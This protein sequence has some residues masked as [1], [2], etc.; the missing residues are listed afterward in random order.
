METIIDRIVAAAG[1]YEGPGDGVES[2][3]FT[4]TIDITPLLDGM[5][6]IIVY[7]AS[8]PDGVVLHPSTPCSHSTCGPARRRCTCCAPS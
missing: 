7:M 5:G 4:A 8:D 3:P 6:A 2:G 1:R